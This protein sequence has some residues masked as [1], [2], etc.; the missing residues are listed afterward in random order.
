MKKTT[1]LKRMIEN[2]EFFVLP[3]GGCALHAKIAEAVGSRSHTCPA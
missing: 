1:V 2:N 3:G